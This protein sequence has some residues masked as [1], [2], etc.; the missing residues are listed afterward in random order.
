MKPV[1]FDYVRAGSLE[2]ALAALAEGGEDA[3]AIAGGQSLVPALTLRL[4]APSLLVDIGRL[5][6]LRFIRVED[7]TVSI[8]ALTRHVDIER[9]EEIRRHAPQQLRA[10]GVPLALDGRNALLVGLCAPERNRLRGTRGAGRQDRVQLAQPIGRELGEV[11]PDLAG[12]PALAAAWVGICQ[13][14]WHRAPG[15]LLQPV[16]GPRQACVEGG[17]R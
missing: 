5:D 14:Q 2:E 16:A 6:E 12:A 3:K 9:S 4:A 15:M 8:G 10:L 7:G 11:G 13:A 17:G 1:P